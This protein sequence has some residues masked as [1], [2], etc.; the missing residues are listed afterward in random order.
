MPYQNDWHFLSLLAQSPSKS[1]GP[2]STSLTQSVLSFVI[3][4]SKDCLLTQWSH[5]VFCENQFI[6]WHVCLTIR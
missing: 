3:W 5:C 6:T 4:I 1:E 2:Y